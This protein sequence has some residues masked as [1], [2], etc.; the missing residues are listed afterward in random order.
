MANGIF[1]CQRTFLEEPKWKDVP[2]EGDLPS[3]TPFDYLV[4]AF[5]NVPS[6]LQQATSN[7]SFFLP[8]A[9][10]LFSPINQ[11]RLQQQILEHIKTVRD[12]RVTWQAKYPNPVW[13]TSPKITP[14]ATPMDGS[15]QHVTEAP[16]QTVLYFTDMYRAYELLIYNT[17][18]ILL[19]MLYEQVSLDLDPSLPYP[20]K[21]LQTLFPNMSLQSLIQDICRCTEYMLLDIHGSRGYISLMLP[22]TIGYFA[23]ERESAEARWLRDVCK[24]HAGSSGFGFGDFSLDLRTP[25]SMWMDDWKKRRRSVQSFTP[26]PELLTPR[27]LVVPVTTTIRSL[28]YANANTIYGR[29]NE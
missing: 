17:T 29:P 2:W 6:Y 28:E 16:F 3:K 12:L 20:N 18:L 14:P 22:A 24:R 5:S 25:L 4:D 7:L 23:S 19:I 26:E 11:A 10:S 13:E 8:T 21:T 9:S 1:A 15:S 27:G